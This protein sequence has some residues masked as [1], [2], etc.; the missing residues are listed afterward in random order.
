VTNNALPESQ[1]NYLLN[2]LTS[3]NINTGKTIDLS[4]QNP[5]AAPTGQGI[6]DKQSLENSGFIVITD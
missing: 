2:K 6:I 1:I 4:N 5:T 3:V